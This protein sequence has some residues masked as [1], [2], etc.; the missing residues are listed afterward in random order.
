MGDNQGV[1]VGKQLQQLL[2]KVQ[3]VLSTLGNKLW[4]HFDTITFAGTRLLLVRISED[5]NVL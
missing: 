4:V 3:R 5:V 2:C 1:L